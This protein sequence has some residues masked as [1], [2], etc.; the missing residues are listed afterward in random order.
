M[1]QA[2]P[3][4]PRREQPPHVFLIFGGLCLGFDRRAHSKPNSSRQQ[5]KTLHPPATPSQ[6]FLALVLSLFPIFTVRVVYFGLHLLISY[7]HTQTH[8]DTDTQTAIM[9]SCLPSAGNRTSICG[10]GSDTISSSDYK[11]NHYQS[12]VKPICLHLQNGDSTHRL[13]RMQST[14]RN[15]DSFQLN[16][17]LKLD[18]KGQIMAEYVWIDSTGE[19]RSKSR[20]RL[21]VLISAYIAVSVVSLFQLLTMAKLFRL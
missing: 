4:S 5:D 16:K 20:V 11:A 10:L 15:T 17:Y 12:I 19:T 6:K 18:Q 9:V 7:Q 21:P 2:H 14:T 1:P 13:N 8:T 3:P